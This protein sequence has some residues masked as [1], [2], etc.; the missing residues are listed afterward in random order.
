[1]NQRRMCVKENLGTKLNK[2][3]DP[4]CQNRLKI[5]GFGYS[6]KSQTNTFTKQTKLAL[7]NQSNVL[8]MHAFQIK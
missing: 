1:M 6:S 7:T 3:T 4:P 2:F 8:S 5:Q